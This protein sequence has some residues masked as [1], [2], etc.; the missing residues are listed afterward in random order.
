M[1]IGR[2]EVASDSVPPDPEH[3]AGWAIWNGLRSCESQPHQLGG[4]PFR[5]VEERYKCGMVRVL[6]IGYNAPLDLDG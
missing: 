6:K 5:I 2:Q 1:P 4:F 3:N